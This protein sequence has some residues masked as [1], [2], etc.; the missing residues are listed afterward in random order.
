MRN[1]LTFTPALLLA[2]AGCADGPEPYREPP[3][4]KVTSPQR[5]L[6]QSGAG[7]VT[8]TG[9]VAPNA[10]GVPVQKVLVNNVQ[11]NVNADGTFNA[12][13]SI[14]EGASFI[15]TI[16][17]DEAGT[18]AFDTRAVHAGQVRT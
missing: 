4:L 12:T 18:E 11:A 8:V 3:V 6:V 14:P 10:D 13:V 17:R 15:E 1:L 16:A 2:F 9:T 5:S 7:Q